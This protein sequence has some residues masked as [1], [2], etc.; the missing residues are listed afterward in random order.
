MKYQPKKTVRCT[1]VDECYL[2]E[3]LKCYGYMTD[4]PLYMHCNDEPC[5]EVRFDAAMDRLIART[6][7]KH[8]RMKNDMKNDTKSKKTTDNTAKTPSA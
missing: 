2:A 8:D 3:E 1:Y 7:A 6:K 5:S 4:C